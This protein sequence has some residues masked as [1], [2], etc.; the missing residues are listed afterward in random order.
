MTPHEK[1]HINNNSKKGMEDW[2]TSEICIH[3]NEQTWGFTSHHSY[4]LLCVCNTFQL[5]KLYFMSRS[6]HKIQSRKFE[7]V[8]FFKYLCKTQLVIIVIIQWQTL[9]ILT[10]AVVC[11]Q[12]LMWVS[13]GVQCKYTCVNRS[14]GIGSAAGSGRSSPASL[15][16]QTLK[17]FF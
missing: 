16:F 8:Y 1:C 12:P 14:S 2:Q 4:S 9:N 10:A 5:N 7:N 15:S 6:L 3:K 13:V 11:F 17:T